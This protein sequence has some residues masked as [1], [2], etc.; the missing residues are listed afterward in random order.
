VTKIPTVTPGKLIFESYESSKCRRAW[1][2][3]RLKNALFGPENFSLHSKP[4]TLSSKMTLFSYPAYEKLHDT[5]HEVS[6]FGCFCR[7]GP[8]IGL[9]FGVQG[10]FGVL[11]TILRFI[12]Y[13]V[14]RLGMIRGTVKSFL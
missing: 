4:G 8:D 1:V 13:H 11:N 10:F 5:Y 7:L 12:L 3:N 9:I 6:F 2:E 14:V